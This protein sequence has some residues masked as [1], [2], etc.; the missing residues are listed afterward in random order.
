MSTIKKQVLNLSSKKNKQPN[1]YCIDFHGAAVIDQDGQE[2]AITEEMVAEACSQ[3][4]DDM[5][6]TS[7]LSK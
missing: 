3:L 2:I 6:M 7:Y 5:P 1:N 4:M